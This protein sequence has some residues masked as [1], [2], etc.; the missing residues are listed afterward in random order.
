MSSPA[1]KDPARP[2]GLEPGPRAV[3]EQEG[4]EVALPPEPAPAQMAVKE[5]EP[6]GGWRVVGFEVALVE[7]ARAQVELGLERVAR[8]PEWSGALLEVAGQTKVATSQPH[9]GRLSIVR[10]SS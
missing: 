8:A 4:R 5:Q 1:A 3:L 7:L 2:R 10:K 6:Y 9:K